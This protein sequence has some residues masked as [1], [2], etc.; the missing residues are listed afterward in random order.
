MSPSTQT[1]ARR[2]PRKARRILDRLCRE[3]K[4]MSLRFWRPEVVET[5]GV[6]LWFAAPMLRKGHRRQIIRGEY[7]SAELAVL[8]GTLA[9]DDTVLELGAGLGLVS[10]FCAKRTGD[11]ARVHVF[12]ANPY[13]HEALK[14]NFALNGVTPDL[15]LM[16]AAKQGGE[17]TFNVDRSYTSSGL[18]GRPS[19]TTEQVRVPAAGFEELV[20]R[21][22]PTYLIMDIEGGEVDLLPGARM[23][24]VRKICLEV[25]PDI[26]GDEPISRLVADLLATGFTL[27]FSHTRKN[28]VYFERTAVAAGQ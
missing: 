19:E 6:K 12:E 13:L 9:A 28:V 20:Q 22:R 14:R 17:V 23:D 5:H 11:A 26:V 18:H 8:D 21:F 1:P 16:A 7:E 24:S 3:L 4:V 10:I 25:H 27:H 2:K 15:H